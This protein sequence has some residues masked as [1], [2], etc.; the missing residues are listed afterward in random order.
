MLNGLTI[1]LEMVRRQM[2][3]IVVSSDISH[4]MQLP[5]TSWA[6]ESSVAQ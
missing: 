6:L 5:F 2:A 3:H 1:Y 4:L